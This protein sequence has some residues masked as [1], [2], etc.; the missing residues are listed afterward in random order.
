MIMMRIVKGRN[1]IYMK[2]FK[3]AAKRTA[4]QYEIT[5]DNFQKVTECQYPFEQRGTQGQIC[6]YG[7]C[8]SCLNPIQLIGILHQIKTAPYG[9]HTGKN[10]SGFPVWKQEKYE[11]CPFS[12]KNDRRIS[13]DDARLEQPDASSIELYNLIK[14]QFDSIVYVIEN[15]LCIRCSKY[16][17]EKVL[18][19]FLINRGCQYPWLTE[20]NLPYIFAYIGMRQQRL[21]MQKIRVN[22]D[23]YHALKKTSQCRLCSYR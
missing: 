21:Y 22:S 23:L 9:K 5:L 20:A 19:Q 8:P 14:L 2:H 17:W 3:T 16:F 12:A 1:R 4:K 10:I 18:Q 6:F 15:A 7:I 13:D 11:Y